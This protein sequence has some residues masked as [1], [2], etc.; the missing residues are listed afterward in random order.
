[1]SFCAGV[2]LLFFDRQLATSCSPVRFTMAMASVIDSEATFEQQA[3]EAGLSQPWM[4]AFKTSN[5]ATVAKL[6]F[7]VTTPGTVASDA[8]ITGFL[9]RIRAGV[10]P[11]IADLASFKRI[12]FEAQTL[13]VHHLKS[14]I[15]GDD[16]S[17]KKI[18][19]PERDARLAQ[20]RALSRGLDT[21]GPLEP[22]HALYDYCSDMIE[23]NTVVYISP[24]K[25]MSRQQAFVCLGELF[26]G[27]LK[28]GAVPGKVLDPYI[29]QLETDVTVTYFM[30]PL[31]VATAKSDPDDKVTKKRPDAVLKHNDAAPPKP[32]KKT[33]KGAGKGKYKRDPVPPGLK[34]MRSRTPKG[35]PYV[36]GT[37]WAH[38]L[39]QIASVN[40]YA[41]FQDVI[42][43]ILN[44]NI[45]SDRRSRRF[46]L[47]IQRKELF[48]IWLMK[49]L[50]LYSQKCRILEKPGLFALSCFVGQVT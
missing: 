49:A 37:I 40:T 9:Q 28:Q 1:M 34:G 11:S 16:L 4:D 7:A 46:H 10:V 13:M 15:K 47:R 45:I 3:F 32:P 35:E 20:Q 44:L 41:R 8:D 19:P 29:A 24:S 22:A 39:Q 42:N 48:R 21:T 33:P 25:C 43:S 14:T 31:P 18:A 17:V 30:L 27:S 23:T 5:M 6:S 36:L 26:T 2:C 50:N 38:V 12:L